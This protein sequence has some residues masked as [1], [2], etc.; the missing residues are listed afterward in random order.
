[1]GNPHHTCGNIGGLK[2]ACAGALRGEKL[3]KMSN[4]KAL[5]SATSDH[6]AENDLQYF[7]STT[8]DDESASDYSEEEPKSSSM[9]RTTQ[10]E[11]AA[12]LASFDFA[13]LQTQRGTTSFVRQIGRNL[14]QMAIN[15]SYDRLKSVN[16]LIAGP[17]G[18]N[19]RNG[20][21]RPATKGDP[22]TDPRL[23]T[24]CARTELGI[25]IETDAWPRNSGNFF[26]RYST[27]W[28]WMAMGK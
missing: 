22:S 14:A 5:M 25:L 19:D 9:R 26:D 11:K 12:K 21:K 15:S 6:V 8:D 23:R 7:E 3:W 18:S 28:I 27:G 24:V 16:F 20:N 13:K 4:T 1:M 17:T 10:S 2:L